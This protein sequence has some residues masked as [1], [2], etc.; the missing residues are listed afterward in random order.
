MRYG[1]VANP[2]QYMQMM[3][4]G[5]HGARAEVPGEA[6]LLFEFMLN[7][8]RLADGFEESLFEERT[9][10]GVDY[11]IDVAA[12]ALADGLIERLETGIWRPTALGKR[13]L[14]DLQ[15]EFLPAP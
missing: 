10:L 15:A 6:D 3:E 7:A 13:F 14:N 9:G 1:K 5:E 8:L 11:L 2:L 12:D 4:A